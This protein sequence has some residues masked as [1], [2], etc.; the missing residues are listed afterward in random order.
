MAEKECCI[1]I[2]N[3]EQSPLNH[4]RFSEQNGLYECRALP[5]LS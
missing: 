3:T 4:D 1:A 5:K 2:E